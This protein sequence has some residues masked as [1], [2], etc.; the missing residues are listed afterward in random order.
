[1]SNTTTR[2]PFGRAAKNQAY[3]AYKC[4]AKK[5]N[6]CFKITFDEP[7]EI[8]RVDRKNSQL[9]RIKRRTNMKIDIGPIELIYKQLKVMTATTLLA[10]MHAPP[11]S[12]EEIKIA[13]SAAATII[14]KVGSTP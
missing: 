14:W 6:R 10:S 7:K 8:F 4:R 13:A 2:L 11:Y 5:Y 3:M 12:D 1:M 9:S